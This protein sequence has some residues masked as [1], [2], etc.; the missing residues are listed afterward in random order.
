MG[1]FSCRA[2]RGTL[3]TGFEPMS[4]MR[5]EKGVDHRRRPVGRRVICQRGR[6]SGASMMKPEATNLRGRGKCL[7]VRN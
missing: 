6:R 5:N 3:G 1:S 2:T 4:V 7:C